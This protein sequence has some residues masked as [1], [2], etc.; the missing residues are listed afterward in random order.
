MDIK[1]GIS[2]ENREATIALLNKTLADQHLLYIQL[3]N[4]HWNLVGTR[5]KS[6]HE[7]FEEQYNALALEIDEVAERITTLGG[8][9][10]GTFKDI[11]S[12]ARIEEVQEYGISDNKMLENLVNTNEAIIRNMRKDLEVIGEKYGDVVTEDLLTGLI[13]SHE[14]TAWMLRTSIG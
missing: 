14:K 9:A 13:Q 6:L 3:R 2:K 5:F 12:N 7:L 10:I 8:T 1:I 11:L 4:Y